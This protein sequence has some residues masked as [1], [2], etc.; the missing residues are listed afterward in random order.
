LGRIEREEKDKIVEFFSG[1]RLFAYNSRY[2]CGFYWSLLAKR[3]DAMAEGLFSPMYD[4]QPTFYGIST[5]QY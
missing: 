1:C 3:I 4:E 5:A 2:F